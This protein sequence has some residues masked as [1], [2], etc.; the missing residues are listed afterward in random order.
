[1]K[2]SSPTAASSLSES[3]VGEVNDPMIGR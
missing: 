2:V 3:R 1:M